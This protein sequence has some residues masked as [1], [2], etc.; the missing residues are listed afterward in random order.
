MTR[1]RDDPEEAKRISE[2]TRWIWQRLMEAEAV[3]MEA[4][5]RELRCGIGAK[6]EQDAL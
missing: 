6:E 5:A 2:S 3:K 1:L 4:A